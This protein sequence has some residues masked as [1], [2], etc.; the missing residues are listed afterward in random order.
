MRH[1]RLLPPYFDGKG[2][3]RSRTRS[4]PENG[5]SFCLSNLQKYAIIPTIRVTAVLNT[6]LQRD[7]ES[8]LTV[9]FRV[10]KLGQKWRNYFL[11]ALPLYVYKFAYVLCYKIIRILYP[12]IV[13][14][15]FLILPLNSRQNKRFYNFSYVG[16]TFLIRN[17]NHSS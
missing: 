17:Q 4:P 7:C 16:L 3:D 9:C 1:I 8:C 12:C 13:Y 2:R 5:T 6:W 14:T 15:R 10:N 11:Q